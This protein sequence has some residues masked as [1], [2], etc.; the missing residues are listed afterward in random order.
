MCC[1]DAYLLFKFFAYLHALMNTFSAM[2]TTVFKLVLKKGGVAEYDKI[3]ASYYATGEIHV[4][5][6]HES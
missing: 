5:E 6:Y 2:Q 4:T 1:Q 3:L